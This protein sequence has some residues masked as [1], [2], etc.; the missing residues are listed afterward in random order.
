MCTVS[1]GN[2]SD[3]CSSPTTKALNVGSSVGKI[4]STGA[5]KSKRLGKASRS[6]N[7]KKSIEGPLSGDDN[8]HVNFV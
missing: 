4:P 5:K 6:K 8:T 2:D 3:L 7:A 1:L